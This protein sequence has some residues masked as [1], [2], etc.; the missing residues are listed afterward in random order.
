LIEVFSRLT[1]W[2][3]QKK[4]YFE[5]NVLLTPVNGKISQDKCLGAHFKFPIS[6]Y[7]PDFLFFTPKGVLKRAPLK[8]VLN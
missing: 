8:G 5:H 2:F 7:S 3:V 6:I 4:A 1:V